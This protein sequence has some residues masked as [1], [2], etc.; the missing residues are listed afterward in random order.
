MIHYAP[1][2]YIGVQEGAE[3]SDLISVKDYAKSHGVT[4]QAVY[5]QMKRK[6]NKEFIDQHTQKI[7]GVKYLDS[8]A[9]AFLEAKKENTPVVVVQQDKDEEIERLKEEN[10]LLM[11]K[12]AGLQDALLQ[13]KG[14]VEQ[15]KDE[16]IILL[17]KAEKKRKW[18]F[19][20]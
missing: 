1:Y 5:Q 12:I 2:K 19:F 10:R 8:E 17:E 20:G 4:I 3:M 15:L 9:V 7:D 18:W 14:K 11:S 16:K 6:N 13:E